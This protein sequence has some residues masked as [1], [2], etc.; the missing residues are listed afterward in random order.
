MLDALQADAGL[1]VVIGSRFCE[2]G[3]TG[4]WDRERVAKSA[5]ILPSAAWITNTESHSSP[6]AE[7]IV[8][9]IKK[10][11]SIEGS[12]AKSCVLFGG[13]SATSDNM[14]A[15]SANRVA[16]CSNCSKSRKRGCGLS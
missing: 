12:A 6:F 14:V 4:E 11:S 2:G 10:S 1:D 15:R 16:T 9:R 13:S 5:G 7:W 8:L 3:C